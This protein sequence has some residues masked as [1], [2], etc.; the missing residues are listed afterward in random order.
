MLLN[1]NVGLLWRRENVKWT[2]WMTRCVTKGMSLQI[3]AAK[4]PFVTSEGFR[5]ELLLFHTEHL[6]RMLPGCFLGV[7]GIS[8][9]VETLGQIQDML[10]GRSELA[11]K[12]RDAPQCKELKEITG[13]RKSQIWIS[14]TKWMKGWKRSDNLNSTVIW[15]QVIQ[16][17]NI[18]RNTSFC[19][20]LQLLS[21]SSTCLL[22]T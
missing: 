6:T 4:R 9:C 14:G 20:F 22:Y 2:C 5:G 13:G 12:C 11:W 10:W 3:Q 21:L 18:Y 15:I 8:G 19:S 7:S 16:V 1:S 17:Q